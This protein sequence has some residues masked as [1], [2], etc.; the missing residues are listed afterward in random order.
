MNGEFDYKMKREDFAGS[1]E[2]YYSQLASGQFMESW[3]P[4]FGT[5]NLVRLIDEFNDPTALLPQYMNLR[6]CEH[7]YRM[8]IRADSVYLIWIRKF[9]SRYYDKLQDFYYF[10]RMMHKNEG[11]DRI[12]K[13]DLWKLKPEYEHRMIR[14]GYGGD[15]ANK[16]LGKYF[17]I[18]R[19]FQG[20]PGPWTKNVRHI[21]K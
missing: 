7:V 5:T 14:K 21:F 3:T 1:D 6:Y 16:S 11:V 2:D 13:K 18:E 19:A 20:Y 9:V 10:N 17:D 15:I 12:Y 8:N 4:E